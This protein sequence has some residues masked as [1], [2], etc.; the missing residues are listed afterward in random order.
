MKGVKSV[1]EV[2]EAGYYGYDSS[3]DRRE[4]SA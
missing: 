3:V 2:G 4:I 1:P